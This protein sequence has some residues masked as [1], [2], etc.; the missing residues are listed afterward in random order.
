MGGKVI[1]I[2]NIPFELSEQQII[3][4]FKDVG[5]IV[6]FRLMFDRETGK[7]RGFAFCEYTDAETAS[8]AIRNLNGYEINGRNLKVDYADQEMT[9]LGP[10]LNQAGYSSSATPSLSSFPSLP[11]T[12]FTS[13]EAINS[14]LAG[15]SNQQLHEVLIQ[16]KNLSLNDPVQSK[17]FLEANPQLSY[18]LFQALILMNAVEPRVVQQVIG[19]LANKPSPDPSKY[20][21]Q[22]SKESTSTSSD[23]DQQVL[24]S[25]IMSLTEEQISALP[26]DQ[27]EQIR[28]I[29]AQFS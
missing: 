29:K 19:S 5:P 16:A 21:L 8:S 3:D 15:M 18:A 1:F 11:N 10:S 13:V 26:A 17:A 28:T 14:T 22:A 24:I 23:A 6:N 9:T 25:Q 27:Q 12:A 7:P 20:N 2:G 4:I